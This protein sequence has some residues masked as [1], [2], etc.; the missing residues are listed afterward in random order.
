[1]LNKN[2]VDGI[3]GS[4]SGVL[5]SARISNINLDEFPP[6]LLLGTKEW[7][8]HISNKSKKLKM[9]NKLKDIINSLYRKNLVFKV[10]QQE[11]L[12]QKL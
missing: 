3:I 11:Y 9:S 12:K 2:R 6:P 5:H 1:M 8:L 10:F 4:K 7:W